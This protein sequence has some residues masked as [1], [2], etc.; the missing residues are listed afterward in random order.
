[1]SR[2]SRTE[3]R[4]PP[5]SASKKLR[6]AGKIVPRH[7]VGPRPRA[8]FPPSRGSGSRRLAKFARTLSIR[9]FRCPPRRPVR[10]GLSQ[11][12]SPDR[13]FPQG[14]EAGTDR[15]CANESETIDATTTMVDRSP[16]WVRKVVR[17]QRRESR[18]FKR[19]NL[20]FS[21]WVRPPPPPHVYGERTSGYVGLSRADIFAGERP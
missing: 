20:F 17:L 5:T 14:I 19:R 9:S 13:P 21:A 8:A 11:S 3:R 16:D 6:G 2:E 18:H 12:P 4:N 10:S 15:P 7:R 1:M